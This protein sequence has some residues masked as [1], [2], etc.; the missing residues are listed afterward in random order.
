M[1]R[2]HRQV[3]FGRTAILLEAL[4][5]IAFLVYLLSHEAFQ[6][7][8]FSHNYT[9]RAEFVDATGLKS[10]NHS[11]VLV[12][13][14]PEG[15][16]Q[17]VSYHDGLAVATLE[18]PNAV[19][20]RIHSDASVS[21]VPRS[22]IMDLMVDIKPGSRAAPVLK[23][24]S[25]IA[26]SRTG[27][28]VEWDRLI[29]VL[30]ADTRAQLQ[31][32]L[33]ELQVGLNGR[34]GQLR[35][36]L[37]QLGSLVDGSTTVTQQLA[38]RRVLLS[39][40]VSTLNTMVTTLAQRQT[41]LAGA[42]DA[43][44][45]TLQV[46]AARST[47]LSAI[48]RSLPP[49]FD[50]LTGAMNALS[51]LAGP[52]DPALTGLAPFAR[53]LPAAL[54]SLR[55]FVPA[56]DALVADLRNLIDKGSTPAGD[57]HSAL[58]ALG[59]SSPDLLPTAKQLLPVLRAVNNDKQG[60]GQVGDNFSGIFSTNDANGVILRGLG[61]FEPFNPADFGFPASSSGAQLAHE[62]TQAVTALTRVCLR[63]NPLACLVRYEV[64]GLPGAIVPL[65]RLP[66]IVGG[67]S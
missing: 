17:S 25:L 22:A 40:L 24:G 55:G 15:R 30:D 52:L 6:L 50:Q 33:G 1:R 10:S 32:L 21:V 5:A 49:A 31:V 66:H 14:V 45:R 56:G 7:P 60:I 2:H 46:T 35:G 65:S 48:M 19:R 67:K 28:T 20:N 43:G 54:G 26:P 4:A 23:P 12:A 8:F 11:P 59:A 42:V 53:A 37:Q 29:D 38:D 13:G 44:Q 64:P 9:V 39:R 36:A 3:P 57:L 27:S 51:S 18:L 62:K 63:V 61:F 41:D 16:V 58:A 34:T 47:Q